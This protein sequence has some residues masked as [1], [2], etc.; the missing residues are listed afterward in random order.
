MKKTNTNQQ[1]TMVAV[2]I[3]A[4][5]AI[6]TISFAPSFA[7]KTKTTTNSPVHQKDTTITKTTTIIIDDNGKK[8]TYTQSSNAPVIIKDM[9]D[10]DDK[11]GE[12]INVKVIVDSAMASIN[13]NEINAEVK[14]V[15]KEVD[16]IDWDQINKDIEQATQDLS[17]VHV[18]E[19][20][21]EIDEAMKSCSPEMKRKIHN[22]VEASLQRSR[23][24]IA[25]ARIEM[26]NAKKAQA[27][28]YSYSNG[29]HHSSYSNSDNYN[30]M[31][32]KMERDGL[33]SRSEGFKIKVAD[34]SLYINGEHQPENI[35][36]KYSD[37][38]NA[39]HITIKGKA[40]SLD[41]RVTN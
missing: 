30:Q 14:N 39:S 10:D 21:K 23:Q 2:F 20:K 37:Y 1:G 38:F 6:C 40:N 32:D 4:A 31:L 16:N 33:I 35:Y 26:R 8:H 17:N 13:W 41:I 12:D 22:E 11:N 7:Q 24:E 27:Y 19:I 5:I 18:E 36:N 29:S 25:Q 9:Q 34:G 28:A 3:A 15:Q